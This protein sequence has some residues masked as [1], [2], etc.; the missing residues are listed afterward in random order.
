MALPVIYPVIN[1][2]TATTGSVM[3][4]TRL[5]NPFFNMVVFPDGRNQTMYGNEA[6]VVFELGANIG[7]VTFATETRAQPGWIADS[8]L[9]LLDQCPQNKLKPE[10]LGIIASN[11]DTPTSTMSSITLFSPP[12]TRV[13]LL[14]DG[15]TVADTGMVTVTWTVSPDMSDFA[16]VWSDS[17]L[18]VDPAACPP[19][20]MMALGFPAPSP[21][22]SPSSLP[23]RTPTATRTATAT[24]TPSATRSRWVTKVV[25][26]RAPLA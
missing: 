14:V 11:D 7:S 15:F 21:S 8:V 13:Y 19:Q 3:V 16:T 25:G 9:L 18:E 12:A 23:S 22:S 6:V 4:D 1:A 2:T 26:S 24:R 5:S 10:D 20:S 17:T